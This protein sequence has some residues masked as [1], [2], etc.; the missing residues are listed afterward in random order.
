[1]SDESLQIF[2]DET[3]DLLTVAE[4]ALLHLDSLEDEAATLDC[5]NDLFRTF[6][7]IKGSAGLFGF[8]DIVNFTHIVESVFDKIREGVLIIN[9]DMVS[10][11]LANRD[12]L[13]YLVKIALSEDDMDVEAKNRDDVLVA[14]LNAYL[15]P[16]LELGAV[17]I[18]SPEKL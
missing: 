9:D 11:F 4:Q 15:S 8:D 7:T 2:A 3:E 17:G 14:K 12:H 10:L 5:I 16:T 1:M 18:D 13:E 6:H